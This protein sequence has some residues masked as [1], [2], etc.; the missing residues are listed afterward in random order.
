LGLEAI[1]AYVD[2][3]LAKQ[4]RWRHS[5]PHMRKLTFSEAEMSFAKLTVFLV[6]MRE[7]FHKAKIY[8]NTRLAESSMARVDSNSI[9]PFLMH[10]L[11][12]ATAFARMEEGLQ[13]GAFASAYSASVSLAEATPASLGLPRRDGLVHYVVGGDRTWRGRR[14][15]HGR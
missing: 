6:R 9:I 10:K 14:R 2:H 7:P 4:V 12:T 13:R 3:I 5:L 11:D 15:R 1:L 8:S